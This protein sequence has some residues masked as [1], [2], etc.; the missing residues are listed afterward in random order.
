MV[1]ETSKE[2]LHPADATVELP[3]VPTEIA[4]EMVP[5]EELSIQTSGA[6]PGAEALL[7]DVSRPYVDEAGPSG[8]GTSLAMQVILESLL[9]PLSKS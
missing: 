5:L 6:G 7:F 2:S 1:G 3:S 8:A 9:I 4:I